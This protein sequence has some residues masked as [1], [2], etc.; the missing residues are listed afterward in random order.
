MWIFLTAVFLVLFFLFYRH[1]KAM[2]KATGATLATVFLLGYGLYLYEQRQNRPG[3]FTPD[4]TYD[5]AAP[6]ADADKET[7]TQALAEHERQTKAEAEKERR[8]Q[9]ALAAAQARLAEFEAS[10]QAA[11]RD[12]KVIATQGDCPFGTISCQMYRLTVTVSNASAY[13]VSSVSLGWVFLPQG[14][15]CPTTLQTRKT[16]RVVL[17]PGDTTVF[18]I[19]GTDGPV[20]KSPF[21]VLVTDAGIQQ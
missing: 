7:L 10:R 13:T 6:K 3:H 8:R 12:V 21:C 11:I 16:E 9:K 14:Q 5:Q 18:N 20:A 19:D 17:R 2:L 1:T 4:I 15:S